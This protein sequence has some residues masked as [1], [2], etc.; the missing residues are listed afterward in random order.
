MLRP[1][2]CQGVSCLY[3]TVTPQM[4]GLVEESLVRGDSGRQEGVCPAKG[5]ADPSSAHCFQV[6][7]VAKSSHF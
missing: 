5:T 1:P 7:R 3:N 4:S 6:E 2:S